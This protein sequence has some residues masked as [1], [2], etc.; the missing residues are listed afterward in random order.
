MQGH[1][2]D[3]VRIGVEAASGFGLSVDLPVAANRSGD[4]RRVFQ[5]EGPIVAEHI[6]DHL[7]LGDAGLLAADRDAVAFIVEEFRADNADIADSLS[8]FVRLE[9]DAGRRPRAMRVLEY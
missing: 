1:H 3:R 2:I 7:D 8:P 9:I 5:H 4:V 6:A